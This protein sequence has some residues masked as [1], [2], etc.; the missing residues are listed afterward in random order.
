MVALQEIAVDR[1]RVQRWAGRNKPMNSETISGARLVESYFGKCVSHYATNVMPLTRGLDA[2]ISNPKKGLV[3]INT[4]KQKRAPNVCHNM[5][6]LSKPVFPSCRRAKAYRV[7]NHLL[8][9]LQ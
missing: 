6:G 3:Y 4:S 5:F 8:A 2:D 1:V 9:Q 7:R